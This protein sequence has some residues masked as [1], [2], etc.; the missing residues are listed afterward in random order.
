MEQRIFATEVVGESLSDQPGKFYQGQIYSQKYIVV[1]INDL[2]AREI[3]E[4]M[5]WKK[6][7]SS[8]K[9]FRILYI[10]IQ[11]ILP[12]HQVLR[13]VFIPEQYE[14]HGEMVWVDKS[15][16]GYH[17]DLCLCYHCK[18]F[19]PGKED[20]CSIAKKLYQ[21]CCDHHLV[22]PVFECKEFE[23]NE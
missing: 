21:I 4:K 15:S 17:K 8:S 18:L 5:F 2:F 14:H 10:N 12:D 1:C 6:I 9:D 16:K 7:E 20:N 19:N 3:S 11:A 13:F 23:N 22:T